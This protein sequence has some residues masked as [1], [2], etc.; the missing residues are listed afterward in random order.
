MKRG[1]GNCNG[2]FGELVQGVINQQSFLITLPVPS[3]KSEAVFIPDD[4]AK[5]IVALLPE[6]RKA[7]QACQKLSERFGLESGGFLNIRSNIPKGKGMASSSADITAALRAMADSYSIRLTNRIISEI[8]AE[9]EPTDGVMYN[10]SVVA[11]DYIKGEL[12]EEFGT[13]PPF[14]IIG[15]DCGGTVDTVQFNQLG[16]RY[17]FDEQQ[18]FNE[19]YELVKRGIREQ[20]L[21]FICKAASISSQI[22]QR[23]LPKPYYDEFVKLAE[24]F[25]GGVVC[26]HSGTVIGVLFDD[27][28]P[29]INRIIS[30]INCHSEKFF[31]IKTQTY[32]TM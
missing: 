14:Y 6:Y 10:E 22:N 12:I 16:K 24:S 1:T 19:A 17:D 30:E 15:I 13:L 26:A 7:V 23:I 21:S 5:E 32:S 28:H 8:A 18:Q 25:G 11:Y 4:K 29:N 9:I 27:N 2:T 20:N 31:L 3:L